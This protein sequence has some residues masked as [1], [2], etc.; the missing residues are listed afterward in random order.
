MK[1]KKRIW[2]IL[3]LIWMAVIFSFSAKSSRESSNESLFVGKTVGR[4]FIKNFKEWDTKEQEAFAEKIEYPVRKTAHATEYAVLGILLIQ[5]FQYQSGWN[6]RRK[7]VIAWGMATLYAVTDEIHQI[8]V[9]GRACM[10]TD[11]MI[12]SGGAMAGIL[13]ITAAGYMVRYIIIGR[14]RRKTDGS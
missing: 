14:K 6:G 4:I 1:K 2:T 5:R 13:L 9:P 7:I 3:I 11:V 10:A 12:D 8:F